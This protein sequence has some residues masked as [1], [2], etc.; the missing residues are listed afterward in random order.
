MAKTKNAKRVE[1]TTEERSEEMRRR[2]MARWQKADPFRN[3]PTKE[4][5]ELVRLA[6]EMGATKKR[7]C[8]VLDISESKFDRFMKD[9]EFAAAVKGGRQYE[10]D[11]LVNK[12]NELAMK[13]NVAC[14]IFLLK[15]RHNY[16]D[17]GVGAATLVEN[18]VSIE[19]KLPDSLSPAKYLETLTAQAPIDVTRALANPGVKQQVIKQLAIEAKKEPE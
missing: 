14:I 18:K 17:S 19:F 7:I 5:V 13:G 11:A 15:S 3:K 9:A 4:A 6:C 10:H 2:V 1:I 8:E 16:V 12:A